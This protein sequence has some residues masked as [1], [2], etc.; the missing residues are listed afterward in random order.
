MNGDGHGMDMEWT[1][2]GHGGGDEDGYGDE[3]RNYT[4]FSHIMQL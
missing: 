4:F 3:V 2:N 1:W